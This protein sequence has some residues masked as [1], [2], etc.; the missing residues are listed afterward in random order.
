[1][2]SSKIRLTAGTREKIFFIRF[3]RDD[4]VGKELLIKNVLQH[5]LEN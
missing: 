2:E 4:D 1:M 3:F 5:S